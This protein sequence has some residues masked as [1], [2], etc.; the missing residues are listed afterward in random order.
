MAL[1]LNGTGVRWHW[2]ALALKCDD[3]GLFL[4]WIVMVLVCD[5]RIAFAL[6]C[7]VTRWRLHLKL[8]GWLVDCGI[9][10]IGG[11]LKRITKTYEKRKFRTL[12]GL[13]AIVCTFG[14]IFGV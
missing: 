14:A 4:H 3:I 13:L 8:I 12:L 11:L 10:E 7:N 9:P 2:M 1:N 5:D 6:E